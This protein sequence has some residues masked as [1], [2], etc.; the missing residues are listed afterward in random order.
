MS[1]CQPFST[2][3]VTIGFTGTHSVREDAASITV[4]VFVLMNSLARDVSVTLSTSDDTAIGENFEQ[5]N[6]TSTLE[7]NYSKLLKACN[8]CKI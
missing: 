1:E 8:R 4:T 5:S 7:T 3:V 2:S 6:K